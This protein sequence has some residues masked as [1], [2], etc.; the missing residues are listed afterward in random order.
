VS[1]QLV[2]GVILTVEHQ[3]LLQKLQLMN[4][5]HQENTDQQGNEG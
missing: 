4:E 5:K 2:I 3:P 1:D